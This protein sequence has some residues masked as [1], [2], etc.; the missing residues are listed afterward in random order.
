MYLTWDSV[1][2]KTRKPSHKQWGANR[3]TICLCAFIW[4]WRCLWGA[5]FCPNL[6]WNLSSL[7]WGWWWQKKSTNR[8]LSL[9][10]NG[11]GK[12]WKVQSVL[13]IPLP[14]KPSRHS[15]AASSHRESD[16]QAQI[17]MRNLHSS[18][19]RTG[20]DSKDSYFTFK[21]LPNEVAPTG[22]NMRD[23]L[24]E[25]SAEEFCSG[26]NEMPKLK[27]GAT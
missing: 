12:S 3:G 7:K 21:L 6:K 2:R 4:I 9:W 5:T 27:V 16:S 18:P 13:V 20:T 23:Q 17:E 8:Y 22:R 24:S 10:S 1:W 14:R 11:A 15:W 19:L 26:H 25:S